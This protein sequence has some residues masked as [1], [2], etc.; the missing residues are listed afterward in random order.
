MSFYII[1]IY[2]ILFIVYLKSTLNKNNKVLLYS[3]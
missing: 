1:L 2:I 3:Y